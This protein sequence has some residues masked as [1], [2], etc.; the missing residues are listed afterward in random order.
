MKSFTF[1]NGK[2]E[3]S[4]LMKRNPRR[5]NWTQIYRRINRK[6]AAEEIAKRKSRMN[7]E[8]GTAKSAIVALLVAL[9]AVLSIL[10]T[11]VSS[12]ALWDGVPPQL[13][14]GLVAAAFLL[15]SLGILAGRSLGSSPPSAAQ[16][17]SSRAKKIMRTKV[18][19]PTFPNGW[20]TPL[21]SLFVS[22]RCHLVPSGT[23]SAILMICHRGA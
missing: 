22:S 14:V 1:L 9:F 3:A 7:H 10:P 13:S 18:Y 23:S 11:M 2:C 8:M 19:P 17:A 16:K 20:Y 15:F 21:Q 6:G 5:T 4:F 12:F